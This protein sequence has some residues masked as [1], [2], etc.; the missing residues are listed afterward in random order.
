MKCYEW[1]GFFYKHFGCFGGQKHNFYLPIKKIESTQ[2]GLE[3]NFTQEQEL[4]H[5][6]SKRGDLKKQ[7]IY[8]LYTETVG[9]PRD[10][11][12]ENQAYHRKHKFWRRIVGIVLTVVLV[13]IGLF[14]ISYINISFVRIY[15]HSAGV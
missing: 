2:E 6:V 14:A 8:Q 11:I 7:G 15:F 13:L 9:E 3:N 12:W 5:L 4:K 10:I 1:K